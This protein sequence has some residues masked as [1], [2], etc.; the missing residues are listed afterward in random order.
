[1]AEYA[2]RRLQF[3]SP[4]RRRSAGSEGLILPTSRGGID[5]EISNVSNRGD[6]SFFSGLAGTN[7][8]LSEGA[9]CLRIRSV[10]NSVAI[11]NRSQ[12]GWR[13][14]S[15]CSIRRNPLQPDIAAARLELLNARAHTP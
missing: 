7:T 12:G 15:L 8:D 4:S 2:A 10:G 6:G 3:S 13:L 9:F 1:M 14:P 11:R 5:R